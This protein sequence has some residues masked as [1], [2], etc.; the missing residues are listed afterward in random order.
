VLES[1]DLLNAV[2]RQILLTA[3][4]LL[5]HISSWVCVQGSTVSTFEVAV[6]T[7]IS[8]VGDA[9]VEAASG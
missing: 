8:K 2:S 7:V 6:K 1:D 5:P 9:P 3:S 4:L